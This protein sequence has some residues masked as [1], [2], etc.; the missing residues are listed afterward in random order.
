VGAIAILA[1][2]AL[3][4]MGKLDADSYTYLV[5]NFIGGVILGVL[6]ALDKQIGFLL[7]EGI[8]ALVSGL[9]IVRKLR[10]LEEASTS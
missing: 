3:S 4:Q 5:L 6:A 2:Y 1:A 8:W 9:G 10:R 7:L